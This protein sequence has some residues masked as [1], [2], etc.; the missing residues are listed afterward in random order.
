M[1]LRTGPMGPCE[2]RYNGV[3]RSSGNKKGQGPCL[4]RSS[5]SPGMMGRPKKKAPV[6]L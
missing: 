6:L 1:P 4:R 2:L 3:L 5:P